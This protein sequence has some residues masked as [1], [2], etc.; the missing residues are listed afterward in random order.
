MTAATARQREGTLKRKTMKDN[1]EK[2]QRN[3]TI[4][5]KRAFIEQF[6][7]S[8]GNITMACKSAEIDRST[9]YRWLDED[10]AFAEMVADV[11]EESIDFAE[12]SLMKQ[13]NSGDTTATIFYLKTKGKKRGYVEKTETESIVKAEVS[14]EDPY[15][16][17]PIESQERIAKVILEERHKHYKA[18]HD[19]KK[20]TDDE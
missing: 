18:T 14:T 17:M 3:T 9:Y 20:D 16:D 7:K 1:D 12:S 8:L 10:Q 13:I 4:I 15:A 11:N 5:K 2:K 19:A 6:R